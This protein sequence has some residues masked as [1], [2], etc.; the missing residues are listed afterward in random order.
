MTL[1]LRFILSFCLL[2]AAAIYYLYDFIHTE[3]RPQYLETVEES[4]N[5]T[6]NILASI[7]GQP[8]GLEILA[9]SMQEARERR[10]LAL[11]YGFRKEKV[12]LDLYLTDEHGRIR[13]DSSS[14]ATGQDY[15]SWNDVLLTLRGRY[16]ARSSLIDPAKADSGA[17]FVAAPLQKEGRITGSLTVVKPKYSVDVLVDRAR[18]KII[19][20]IALTLIALFAFTLLFSVWV[21]R[22][23]GKL[24]GY[25]EALARGED[26]RLPATKAPEMR[27]LGQA[28]EKMRRELEGKQ[29]VEQTLRTLTHELRSPLSGLVANLELLDQAVRPEDRHHLL[30]NARRDCERL[31][32]L[33]EH[34]L[35]LAALENRD[36]L[37]SPEIVSLPDIARRAIDQAGP[38]HTITLKAAAEA[39]QIRAYPVLLEQAILSLIKNA[40]DFSPTTSSIE[41]EIAAAPDRWNVIV[42][43]EGTGILT[44]ALPHVFERFYS[45]ERPGGGRSTGLGL[46]IVR[47][48]A[49]LHGGT[50][51]ITNRGDKSGTIASISIPR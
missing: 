38:G 26:A 32:S 1:R 42:R 23:I 33:C 36:S 43:D 28:F 40:K 27:A 18:S 22:P 16:G 24:T 13:Y 7:A 50:V 46:A 37:A 45:T 31:Q 15:S 21:T 29:Y 10:L 41:V 20:G 19:A 30:Q 5:D 2:S 8:L 14:R 25:V 11:I 39:T 34:V 51:Q 3:I 6:A 4:L 44:S 48:V 17:L 47:E 12:E 49:R 35:L 9:K